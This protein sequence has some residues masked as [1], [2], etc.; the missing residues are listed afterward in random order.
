MGALHLARQYGVDH[1]LDISPLFETPEALETGGRFVERLLE[2]AAFRDYV[3]TRG[4]P[5]HSFD[6]FSLKR[7]R[8]CRDFARHLRGTGSQN[9]DGCEKWGPVCKT[10]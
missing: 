5:N 2:E 1:A 3:R 10:H 8:A 4:Y 6:A 7:S 9:E